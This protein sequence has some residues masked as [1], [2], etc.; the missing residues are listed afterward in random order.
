MK[1]IHAQNWEKLRK[2]R[3]W[4]PF[5]ILSFFVMIVSFWWAWDAVVWLFDF[6]IVPPDW[7]ANRGKP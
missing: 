2:D 4:L 3:V 1:K 6:S 5:L 7:D